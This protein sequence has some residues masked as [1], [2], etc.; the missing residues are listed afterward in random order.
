MDKKLVEKLEEL[1][2]EELMRLLVKKMGYEF[3]KEN[4]IDE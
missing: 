4:I 1:N 3:S 2:T